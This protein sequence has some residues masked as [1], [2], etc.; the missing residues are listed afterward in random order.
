[1][2][3]TLLLVATGFLLGQLDPVGFIAWQLIEARLPEV[4]AE[5]LSR[6]SPFEE[7]PSSRW[8]AESEHAFV[9]DDLYAPTAAVHMLVIP[10]QRVTSL[11]E[12]PPALL[13]E[14]LDLARTT[15]R[16]RGIADSGFRVVINTNPHGAQ[17][18]YHLHMHVKGGQ[19]LPEDLLPILWGRFTHRNA[20]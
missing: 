11:L 10:K 4:K 5:S 2:K 17:T 7:M 20:G 13:G 1:M 9:I 12:A 3:K 15:A 14:M 16:E 19:Q 6:P 18:V 8:V